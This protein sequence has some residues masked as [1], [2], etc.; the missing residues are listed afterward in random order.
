MKEEKNK[1]REG[2]FKK[3]LIKRA[4]GY[5]VKEVVEEFV[6]EEGQVRLSK[7]KVTTKNVPP[8]ITALKILI[9]ENGSITDMTDEELENERI[10]LLN[11]LAESESKN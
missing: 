8:D 11:I 7:K 4:L 2:D 1:N 6:N 3:A 5:N 10:R 9:E